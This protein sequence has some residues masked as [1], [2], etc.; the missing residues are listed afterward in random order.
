MKKFEWLY[1][2]FPIFICWWVDVFTKSWA[3]SLNEVITYGPFNFLLH[4]N[5]G[6]ML[7]LFSELPA[8]LRIV[9]LATG[10]AFL[11]F[12]YALIQYLLPIK[13][14]TLRM[15]LSVLIG[16]ILGNVTDRILWGHVVDFIVIG[17]PLFVSP[18]FNLAD[19]IQWVGYAMIVYAIVKDGDLLW[20]ENNTRKKLW[21]NFKF[22]FKYS[23]LLSSFGFGLTLISI[24]FS[25]TY[26]KVTISELVGQ[27]TYVINKFLLPFIITYSLIGISFCIILFA[28]GRIISHRM[29]GPL[30][31]FERFIKEVTAG[32]PSILKL[33]SGDEFQHLEGI[34]QDIKSHVESLR[35]KSF[36][37][38][39]KAI[40]LPT[41]ELQSPTLAELPNEILEIDLPKAS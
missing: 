25:Y 13:S 30:F 23:M 5:H 24:V 2:L 1:V 28:V 18:A 7:G 41:H 33:R 36:R 4:H 6:A 19:A 27:N 34:S 32:R 9:T 10:G 26:L 29:A 15:G 12:S 14:L 31:A 22:Q 3:T 35:K 21:V 38:P 20:P 11:L 17:T 8:V 39:V 16:G 40:M 37:G